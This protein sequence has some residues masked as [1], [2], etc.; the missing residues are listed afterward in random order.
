[1]ETVLVFLAL[2]AA[3]VVVPR[4]L[5]LGRASAAIVK[6]KIDAGAVI[7]DVRTPDE[8]R[9][10]AYRGARNI[11]L[12]GL[13][14]RLSEIPKNKPVIVYCASGMRSAAAARKLKQA[15]YSDV[16]NAGG[17]SQMP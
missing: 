14:G 11:P 13:S 8:F 4:L 17:L 2:L 3:V 10:G 9:G 12:D 15:G 1:M 16:T 5:G 7:V 6:Q